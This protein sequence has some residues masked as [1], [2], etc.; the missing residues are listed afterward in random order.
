MYLPD[1]EKNKYIPYKHNKGTGWT[2]VE[3][4]RLANGCYYA[5][6]EDCQAIC[7]WLMNR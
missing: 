5:T 1:L 3:K 4:V 7:D 2:D 6:K